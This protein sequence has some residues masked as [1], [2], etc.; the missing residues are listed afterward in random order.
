MR[1]INQY[2]WLLCGCLLALSACQE[3]V[4]P[5][6][7]DGPAILF[8]VG[9]LSDTKGWMNSSDLATAGTQLHVYDILTDFVGKVGNQTSTAENPIDITYI[10][11]NIGYVDADWKFV[12]NS[13]QVENP[14]Y[15][16]WTRTGTHH[17]FGWLV[18]DKD[19]FSYSDMSS[20]GL[21]YDVNNRK[22]TVEP[23]TFTKEITPQF[24][25][26]YSDLVVRNAAVANDQRAVDLK[27]QHLFSAMAVRI[28]NNG[29]DTINLESVTVS[30][31]FNE[32]KA[33]V[34]YSFTDEHA[35][36]AV[37]TS[38]SKA[39]FLAS[40]DGNIIMTPAD[41][42]TNTAGRKVNLYTGADYNP[43]ATNNYILMWPQTPDEINKTSD[44]D[45]QFAYF[46]VTYT[47]NG[48]EDP[49]HAGQ[50]Q[51]FIKQVPFSRTGLFTDANNNPTGMDAGKKYSFVL[52]F[53]EKSI[54]LQLMVMPWDYNTYD[55]D[56]SSSTIQ[57]WSGLANDG[58]LWLYTIDNEGVAHAGD[59][60]RII[61][62]ESGQTIKGDFRIL[63]PRSGQW[64]ITTYPAEA[65][66]YF[67]IMLRRVTTVN[68]VDQI[69]YYEGN[70]GAIGD[71]VDDH[72]NYDGYVEFYVFPNGAVTAQQ[73]LHFNV[74]IMMNGSWRNANSEFNRKD[75]KLYREP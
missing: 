24:D 26:L 67:K 68:G 23:I 48:V 72:G 73:E 74:D 56:Y 1:I 37:Y 16:R 69:E 18:K 32:K 43:D 41:P 50:L 31:V 8:S 36:E 53:K 61:T 20:S 44:T 49:D 46:T 3:K 12:D 11:K 33:S 57:A 64:Q 34:S 29:E 19:G 54:D 71:L 30:G 7:A 75:W 62:M 28:E 60:N 38:L 25:F 15:Y 42:Q 63:S 35:G 58:V 2:A 39:N 21:S 6:V 52:Q 14:A 10:D 9:E 70:S 51:K 4:E 17:F 55:L 22:L 59:R 40:W 45:N 5:V 27:M 66:Q 65:A 13:D 47:I